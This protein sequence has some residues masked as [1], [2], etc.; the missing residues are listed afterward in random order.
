LAYSTGIAKRG[1]STK[2]GKGK[3][4]Y[5]YILLTPTYY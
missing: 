5:I 3:Y 1:K 4:E 2:E